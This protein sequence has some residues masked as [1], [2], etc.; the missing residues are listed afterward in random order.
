MS[1]LFDI[2][3]Y[4]IND[5]PGIRISLFY[6]GCPLTCV[7][8]HNPEGIKPTPERMYTYKRCIGCNYCVICCP[9]QA[10][11]LTPSG[12]KSDRKRCTLCGK[13]TEVCPTKAMELSGRHYTTSELMDE[14]EK[15]RPFM[16]QSNGGVTFCGGEPLMHFRTLIP[17]LEECG[18]KGIH[19]TV[20]TTLYA[21]SEVIKQVAEHCDLF[22]ID[23]KQMNNTLH[24]LMCG[25]S[26]KLIL[27]N[28]KLV[29]HLQKEYYIRIPLIEGFNCDDDKI[30]E[31][32]EFLIKLEHKPTII[33]L[34]PYHDIGRVKHEKLGTLYN[35]TGY[36]LSTPNEKKQQKIVHRFQEHG[37]KAKI[38][39]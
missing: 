22:L 24:R 19:R 21:S 20:D 14:I 36:L 16:E 17:I 31:M 18:V 37:L 35:P 39:G 15:E 32:I 23:L 30:D 13:C 4:A 29:S 8:C 6:K 9:E 2:K 25:V 11:E 12:I 1:L 28:L 5:G 3:R 33:N 26:N 38:G 34:L 10:L 27:E 7:W